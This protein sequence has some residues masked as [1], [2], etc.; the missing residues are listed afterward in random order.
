VPIKKPKGR[1][2]D[3]YPCP[4][5][6]KPHRVSGLGYPLPSLIHVKRHERKKYKPKNMKKRKEKERKK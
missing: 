2:I 4:N 3:L 5:R 6:V 1:E